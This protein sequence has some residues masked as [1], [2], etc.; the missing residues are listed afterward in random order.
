MAK[1]KF[2]GGLK[3]RSVITVKA[4]PRNAR[5]ATV[6]AHSQVACLL[7]LRSARIVMALA[8]LSA[9]SVMAKVGFSEGDAHITHRS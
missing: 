8:R 3:C 2:I 1:T 4:V 5:N 9:V 7:R 6:K